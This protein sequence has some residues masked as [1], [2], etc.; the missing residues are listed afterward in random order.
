MASSRVFEKLGKNKSIQK[1]TK[2]FDRILGGL[3]DFIFSLNEN[4][5]IA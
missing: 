2:C 3:N 4:I 1:L 5:F